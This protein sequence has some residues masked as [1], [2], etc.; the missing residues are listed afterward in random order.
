M[1]ACILLL[2][3]IK[4]MQIS[5]VLREKKIQKG[6]DESLPVISDNQCIDKSHEPMI[7]YSI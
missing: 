6:G 2:I 7:L 3:I 1:N 4:T 5:T